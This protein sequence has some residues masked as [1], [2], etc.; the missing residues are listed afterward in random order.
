MR[1]AA[2]LDH[3]GAVSE[4]CRSARAGRGAARSLRGRRRQTDLPAAGRAPPAVPS[5]AGGARVDWLRRAWTAR[6]LG[7]RLARSF[8]GI[9]GHAATPLCWRGVTTPPGVSAL[10]VGDLALDVVRSPEELA[11]A[12]AQTADRRAWELLLCET[13]AGRESWTLAGVC[14]A[15]DR[16]VELSGDWLY[17]DGQVVNF[18]ERRYA[19]C[20]SSTTASASWLTFCAP[21]QRAAVGLVHI[22]LRAGDA[23]LRVGSPQPSRR[24]GRQRVPRSRRARGDV[25]GGRAPRGRTGA[26]LRRRLV[27]TR[28]SPTTSSSTFRTSTERW[29]SARACCGPAAAS[30]SPSRSTRPSTPGSARQYAR[31]RSS[32]S[33][34]PEYHGNPVDPKGSLVFYEHGWDILDRCRKAGFADAYGLC[35]WSLL[36][37]YL[38]A[39]L[40]LVFVAERS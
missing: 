13:L 24:R 9:T 31:A 7:A 16:A 20:A 11:A 30:T 19:P 8:S 32:S 12:R 21:R 37:G 17:S 22:S 14:K 36:Y 39:G 18:G 28:S 26:Q 29:P 38:G 2:G 1:V 10:A 35:Y 40:Q 4:R 23:V 33:L 25:G 3:V 27:S 6:A 5:A 34:P 15:C